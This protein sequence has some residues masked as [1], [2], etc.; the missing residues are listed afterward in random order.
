VLLETCKPVIGAVLT[1]KLIDIL[2]SEDASDWE[3]QLLGAGGKSKRI[4]PLKQLLTNRSSTQSV[5]VESVS[6]NRRRNWLVVREQIATSVYR[7]HS[8]AW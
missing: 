7:I 8:F 2:N 5:W 4:Q 1:Q 3:A 6:K